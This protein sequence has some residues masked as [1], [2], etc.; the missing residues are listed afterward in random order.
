MKSI[1]FSVKAILH[2]ENFDWEIFLEYTILNTIINAFLYLILSGSIT[3]GL[4]NSQYDTISMLVFLPITNFY[5][6]CESFPA[7][8]IAVKHI[9]FVNCVLKHTV[10]WLNF[11]EFCILL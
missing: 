5:Y 2:R 6:N 10:E 4:I 7:Q 9:V 3:Y 11:Q 1:K 8:K